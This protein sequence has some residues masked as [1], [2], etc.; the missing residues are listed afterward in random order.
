MTDAVPANN[1]LTISGMSSKT[2]HLKM[3]MAEL[4]ITEISILTYSMELSLS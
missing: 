1:P 2:L 3:A 4:T